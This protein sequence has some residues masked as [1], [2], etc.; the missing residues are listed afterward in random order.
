MSDDRPDCRIT[1]CN[2]PAVGRWH[3]GMWT[4]GPECLDHLLDHLDPRRRLGEYRDE[5][6]TD[7]N[8]TTI[9]GGQTRVVPAGAKPIAGPW[10]VVRSQEALRHWI[11]Q[12]DPVVVG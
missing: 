3:D 11:E 5:V 1:D 10:A 2:A 12:H 8:L 4:G 7:A 6:T 9:G